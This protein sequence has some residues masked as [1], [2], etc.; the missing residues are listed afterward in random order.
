MMKKS[1]SSQG[2]AITLFTIGVFMAGM[3]NGII[4][5][6]L[7][8]INDSFNVSP[9][10]G[11]WSI[12]LYTLGIAI[13]VPVIGKLSDRYGRRRLFIIE[14]ALFGLGSLLVAL[15]PNFVFLLAARLL[16]AFGGGGIFII[17][18][19]HILSTLP[20]EKQ[21]KALGMLG[22]MHGLSAVIGPNLGAV[23]LSLTGSWHWMFLINIPIA[24]FL[25]LFGFLKIEESNPGTTKPLDFKGT[26]L[27][28]L[29]IL[30]LMYG[31]TQLNSTA[32]LH[33]MTQLDVAPFL[34]VGITLLVFL[35]F[36]E[37]SV[38]KIGGDPI[39]AFSLLRNRLFQVTLILGLLSGGFLSGIIFIPSFVQQVLQVPVEHAGYWL[40][41]L[42]VASG[43]GAGL[44]GVFTDKY[45]AV[46]T[47]ILSGIVGVVGFL[48]FPLW[49]DGFMTFVLASMLAGIG[50]GILLGAPLNVLV[51]ESAIEG[52]QGSAL[53]TLS[54]VR[55]IGL[56]LF[57]TL[58]AGFITG[59][60]TKIE[61]AI[62]QSFGEKL[63][64]SED[65]YGHLI[66]SIEKIANP[67]RRDAVMI[68]V[69]EIIQSGF[70]QMFF[71]AAVLSILVLLLGI[72]LYRRRQNTS[73]L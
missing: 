72:Y 47:I 31:I 61:P 41:P 40:T 70:S 39:L 13:S 55:Q 15:S 53:G 46:K 64:V 58:Y 43:I 11:T 30:A 27:L 42:A 9:S 66:N 57:P 69:Q 2:W 3:D 73:D 60:F 10:W 32:F 22:G 7:T 45:G 48:L 63:T 24:A 38:E 28:S 56:T 52:E 59:A 26:I 50:L 62:Q 25:I 37:R 54:L 44:G 14:I 33:S 68:K 29:G 34:I 4:S 65:N 8:T 6:A 16:Q 21:G 36:H 35:I 18:S 5:T 23:I 17:G 67:E 1:K 51:G 12:T 20:K 49:V 19:S 71:T